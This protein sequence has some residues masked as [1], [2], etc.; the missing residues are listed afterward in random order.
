MENKIEHV[1]IIVTVDGEIH[2][3]KGKD[4]L[5]AVF[6]FYTNRIS[7]NEFPIELQSIYLKD[8]NNIDRLN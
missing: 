4:K 5:D 2:E 7:K 3:C 1:Y 6:N 8:R